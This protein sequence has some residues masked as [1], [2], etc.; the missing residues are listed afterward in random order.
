VD[1]FIY[2][3]ALYCTDC[4]TDVV[5]LVCDCE[6]HGMKTRSDGRLHANVS[7]LCDSECTP[8]GPFADGGGES[9]TP[10]HCDSCGVFLE[11]SLTDDGVSYVHD[12]LGESEDYKSV[13]WTIWEP[14]YFGYHGGS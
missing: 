7:N 3:A 11:N 2:R 12:A 9:D 4:A 14:F 13:A 5:G 8:M 6:H 10:Q 1:A